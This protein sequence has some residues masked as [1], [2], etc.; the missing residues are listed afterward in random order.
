MYNDY[1]GTWRLP[2]IPV[3]AMLVAYAWASLTTDPVTNR[4]PYPL[5]S[6]SMAASEAPVAHN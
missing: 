6:Q 2:L 3:I 5:P 1:R 4:V